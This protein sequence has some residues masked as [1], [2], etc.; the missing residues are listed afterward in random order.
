MKAII[1]LT[2][3]TLLLA[4]ECDIYLAK[5]LSD[6]DKSYLGDKKSE[7]YMEV[8]CYWCFYKTKESPLDSNNE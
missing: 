1:I 5:A 8:K 7:E 4:K 2:L 6:L 3:S